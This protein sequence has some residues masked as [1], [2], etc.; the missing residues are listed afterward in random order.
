MSVFN[1]RWLWT[2]NVRIRTSVDGGFPVK[3][4]C[5]SDRQRSDYPQGT[6]GEH[7]PVIRRVVVAT[8]DHTLWHGRRGRVVLARIEL[9]GCAG[10]GHGRRIRIR[11]FD[12]VIE[13][14]PYGLRGITSRHDGAFDIVRRVT[15]R[16]SSR[17]GRKTNRIEKPCPY[18]GRTILNAVRVVQTGRP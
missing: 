6:S 16:T 10:L 15:S 14:K 1:I 12:G 11:R 2:R 7:T 9:P 8:L 3:T 5:R 4:P 13:R 18:V 17:N